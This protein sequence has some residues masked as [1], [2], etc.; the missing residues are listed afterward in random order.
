MEAYTSFASVYDIFMD[1]VPYQEWAEYLHGLLTE[2]HVEK[3]LLLDLGCGTGTITEL[4]AGYG[5]DMIGVD[6]SGEMLEAAFEKREKS[7]YDILYLMQDMREFELYGTVRAAVS[8]CDSLNYIL[9]EEELVQ[10]FRLVNNY[11]DPGGIF[12]FDFNTDYKYREMLGN[13][14]I[15]EDREKCSFIW[16]NYYY[17]EEQVNEYEL[18]LFIREDALQN[19]PDGQKEKRDLPFSQGREVGEWFRRFRETHF[20]KG[21]TPK[22]MKQ[23]AEEAGM[24]FLAAFDAFTRECPHE[25]SERVCMVVRECTKSRP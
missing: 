4:L 11:L 21:Y 3:G 17:E 23:V 9:E 1:N 14:T 12:I 19:F 13:Q 5:Y 15:A 7:G 8:I 2:Y 25:K 18:T 24:E 20:Q 10:V 16:D 22:Q 6:N